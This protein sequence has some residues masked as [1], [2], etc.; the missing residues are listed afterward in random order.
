MPANTILGKGPETPENLT[1]WTPR[2]AAAAKTPAVATV[3]PL[4]HSRMQQKSRSR[5]HGRQFSSAVSAMSR[6]SSWPRPLAAWTAMP[7]AT[8]MM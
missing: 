1:Q 2:S 3:A 8:V 4:R 7:N 5:A 6:S